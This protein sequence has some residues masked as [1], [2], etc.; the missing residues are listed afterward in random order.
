M[1]IGGKGMKKKKRQIVAVSVLHFFFC[2]LYSLYCSSKVTWHCY[3]AK[4]SLFS[5]HFCVMRFLL[6]MNWK[7]TTKKQQTRQCKVENIFWALM[8]RKKNEKK[9]LPC[10]VRY[11]TLFVKMENCSYIWGLLLMGKTFEV[12]WYQNVNEN[13]YCIKCKCKCKLRNKDA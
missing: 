8:E 9:K 1:K 10:E 11:F 4:E 12:C 3:L 5:P 6:R 2:F 7:K 13:A